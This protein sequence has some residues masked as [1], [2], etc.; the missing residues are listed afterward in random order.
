MIKAWTEMDWSIDNN[1]YDDEQMWVILFCMVHE[2]KGEL[3]SSEQLNGAFMR[4]WFKSGH[5]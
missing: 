3:I 4:R 1:E 2:L 5:S